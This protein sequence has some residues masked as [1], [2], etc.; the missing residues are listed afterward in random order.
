METE[1]C[2]NLVC[3]AGQMVS[4]T[5]TLLMHL[6]ERSDDDISILLIETSKN[7]VTVLGEAEK[8]DFLTKLGQVGHELS[9]DLA[10]E[11]LR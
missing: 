8:T 6:A 3:L 10:L 9:S 2:S 5:Q 11:I 4:K 1:D 7:R